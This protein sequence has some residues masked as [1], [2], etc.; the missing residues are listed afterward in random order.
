M[1]QRGSR[2]PEVLHYPRTVAAHTEL[3]TEIVRRLSTGEPSPV[4]GEEAV[5]VWQ[6]MAAAYRACRERRHVRVA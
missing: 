2:E 1:W 3:V 6:I 5:A 4:P